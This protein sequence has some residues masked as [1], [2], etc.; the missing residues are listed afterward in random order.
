LQGTIDIITGADIGSFDGSF[1][2][3]LSLFRA[4]LPQDFVGFLASFAERQTGT[5]D[6]LC[7]RRAALFAALSG[8]TDAAIA[9]LDRA[10]AQADDGGEALFAKALL[11]LAQDRFDEALAAFRLA[12]PFVFP[13][14]EGRDRVADI[15]RGFAAGNRYRAFSEFYDR[16]G[17]DFCFLVAC[18]RI[19]PIERQDYAFAMDR[20]C[21]FLHQ[22]Y[23]IIPVV[24]QACDSLIGS[25]DAFMEAGGAI[26]LEN[27]LQ[28][29]G[30]PTISSDR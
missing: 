16:F 2:Q 25:K 27:L 28:G 10:A 18:R 21:L 12:A 13:V 5:D 8:D 24:L 26:T 19:R 11:H 4:V 1:E 29:L 3:R 17:H 7:L 15:E 20:T 30:W 22:F 9:A 14:A 6:A 23:Q